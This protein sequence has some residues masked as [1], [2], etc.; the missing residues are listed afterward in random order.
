MQGDL[1]LMS[2]GVIATRW[3]RTLETEIYGRWGGMGVGRDRRR[4]A[5][6]SIEFPSQ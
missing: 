3:L 6:L 4:A 2:P 1:E 5:D